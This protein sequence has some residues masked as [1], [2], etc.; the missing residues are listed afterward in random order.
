MVNARPNST[1]P[2]VILQKARYAALLARP[3]ERGAKAVKHHTSLGRFPR[4]GSGPV[5]HNSRSG[6]VHLRRDENADLLRAPIAGLD[7]ASWP[8]PRKWPW[9]S[10]NGGCPGLL[11]FSAD[12]LEMT[13]RSPRGNQGSR[14]FHM[15]TISTPYGGPAY[16]ERR[17][18]AQGRR[19]RDDCRERSVVLCVCE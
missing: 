12:R 14:H 3:R 10:G 8:C 11:P 9:T 6:S 17:R 15:S 18:P 7:V 19:G 1:F 4:P 13:S 5:P 2:S 16:A